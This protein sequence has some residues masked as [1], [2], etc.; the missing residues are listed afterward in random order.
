MPGPRISVVIPTRNRRRFLEQAVKLAND[1]CWGTLSCCVLIH[2]A[3][4][5]AHGDELNQALEDLRYGAIGINLWPGAIY[6]LVSPTWGAYPG[7]RPEDIQS[8]SG[9]V[10]NTWMFDHPEK[11]I[12]RAPFRIRPTPAWFSDHKN[13]LDLGRKLVAFEAAPS[14]GTFARVALAAMKG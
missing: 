7:H 2:P 9:V 4:E 3:T 13:L 14:W 6:G 1:A 10:H 8:G 12:V 11:S 5:E